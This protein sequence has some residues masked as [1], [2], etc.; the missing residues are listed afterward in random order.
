MHGF[1]HEMMLSSP[2]ARLTGYWKH[3]RCED[4][5]GHAVYYTISVY[6]ETSHDHYALTG[7]ISPRI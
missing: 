6:R 2:G 4:A 3:Q 5:T 1:F 7:E